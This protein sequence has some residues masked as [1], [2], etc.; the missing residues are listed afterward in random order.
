MGFACFRP[1][2]KM[3]E[4]EGFRQFN[5][6]M[7][8]CYAAIFFD[9]DLCLIADERWVEYKCT[10]V[11]FRIVRR[12]LNYE[13]TRYHSVVFDAPWNR[14]GRFSESSFLWHS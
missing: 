2:T 4:S 10:I 7:R 8:E 9:P 13:G 3:Q 5:Y 6:E 11:E 1:A 14:R 12:K